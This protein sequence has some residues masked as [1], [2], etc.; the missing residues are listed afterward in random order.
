MSKSYKDMNNKQP[1]HLKNP[2]GTKAFHSQRENREAKQ[3]IDKYVGASFLILR[4]EE[5]E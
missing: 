3:D 2:E 4:K 5:G 1:K